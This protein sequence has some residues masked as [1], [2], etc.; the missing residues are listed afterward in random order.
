DKL[1]TANRSLRD[2][3]RRRADFIAALSHE[4]R[5]PLTAIA[6]SAELLTE[7]LAEG[8]REDQRDYL[9]MIGQSV[10]HVRRLLEDVL[11]LAKLD[12]GASA[13]DPEAVSVGE[14]LEEAHLLVAGML[15]EKNLAFHLD[16]QDD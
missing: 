15:S 3:D 9:R 12:A 14:I 4:L 2:L 6:G 5:T 1:R 16:A 13:I 11:D 8:L 10:S 7:D